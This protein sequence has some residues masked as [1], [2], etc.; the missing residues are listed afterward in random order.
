MSV[1]VGQPAPDFELRDQHGQPVRLSDYRG[2]KAVALIFYP[3]AF[4]RTCQGELCALRDDW[5]EFD[6]DEVAVLTVSV[7]SVAAHRRWAEDQGYR[8]PLLADFWPHGEVAR[9]YGVFNDAFGY[10]ERATFL[11]DRAGVVRWS[12]VNPLQDARSLD[13][14]RKAIADL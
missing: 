12:V 14:L 9:S 8:F 1:D 4:T 5:D 13:D 7:D 11:I 3:F 10:A 2:K 6:T